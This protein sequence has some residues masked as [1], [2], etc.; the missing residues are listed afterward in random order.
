MQLG[1]R[2]A[3][4]AEPPENVPTPV[5]TAIAAEE[6]ELLAQGVDTSSWRWTL[7]WLERRPVVELDDG[8][9]IRQHADGSVSL[10]RPDE[11]HDDDED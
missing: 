4:G 11:D 9:T 1:T 8:T 10:T 2:W 3:V 7:T 5:Q 6:Q